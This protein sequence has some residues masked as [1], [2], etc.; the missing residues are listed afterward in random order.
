MSEL[1]SKTTPELSSFPFDRLLPEI[2]LLVLEAALPDQRI[3][4]VSGHYHYKPSA[5]DTQHPDDHRNTTTR[6]SKFTFHIRHAPPAVLSVCRAARAACLRH[7]LFLDGA[8]GAFFQPAVD[9]LYLD[10]NDRPHF[11][12]NPQHHHSILNGSSGG[13]SSSSTP[14]DQSAWRAIRHIGLEWRAFFGRTPRVSPEGTTATTD[15]GKAWREALAPLRLR[16]PHLRSLTYV[17]PKVRHPG[18]L[19]WGREPYGAQKFAPELVPLP[20]GT[21][22]PWGDALV[23]DEMPR[24]VGGRGRRGRDGD[25]D[26]ARLAL[27]QMLDGRRSY[28]VPWAEMR[29]LIET[30]LNGEAGIKEEDD[31]RWRR[32]QSMNFGELP[33]VGAGPNQQQ[34]WPKLDVYGSWLLRVNA[35]YDE[36]VTSFPN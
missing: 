30:S 31:A 11:R 20:E 12:Q 32:E 4:H 17:L 2:Q 6:S 5:S 33:P 9:M 3:F 1:Q 29:A 14:I 21:K 16:M 22:V 8:H 7:G 28:L 10:R 13:G 34:N 35:S 24:T 18:G 36:D 26:Q 15:L 27:A 25:R 19:A 23:L